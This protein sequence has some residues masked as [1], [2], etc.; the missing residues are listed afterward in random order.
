[1][2]NLSYFSFENATVRTLGAPDCPLFVAL[3][4][5]KILGYANPKAAPAKHVY[6]EDI[7]KTEIT[8][9]LGRQQTVNC[10]N[11]SGLYA[12]IFGS[13]LESAKRFKRWVTSEVLPAIRRTGRYVVPAR[14]KGLTYAEAGVIR[15]AVKAKVDTTRIYQQTI[16]NALFTR[17]GVSA[18]NQLSKAQIPHALEFIRNFKSPL[19][20]Y[21]LSPLPQTD[22]AVVLD[23]REA[24]I[25]R[26]FIFAWRYFYRADLDLVHQLLS[27]LQS[28]LS[29]HFWEAV[30]DTSLGRIERILAQQGYAVSEMPCYKRLMEAKPTVHF[31]TDRLALAE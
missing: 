2:S 14:V 12:L 7:V 30:H 25:L 10:V 11:E 5:A 31:P 23:S 21:E 19:E 8:D 18:T 28:P 20:G 27:Q 16:Y 22:G 15:K 26:R 1:M 6:P 4:V 17:F 3:D 13:K 24:E 29:P 9:K